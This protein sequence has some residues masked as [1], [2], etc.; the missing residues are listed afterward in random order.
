MMLLSDRVFSQMPKAV[1]R[2][3]EFIVADAGFDRLCSNEIFGPDGDM[4]LPAQAGGP[5]LFAE[6]V[7]KLKVETDP[8]MRQAFRAVMAENGTHEQLRTAFE[9]R[10]QAGTLRGDPLQEALDLGIVHE[11]DV[12]E[13]SH[14]TRDD[15]VQR[16]NWLIVRNDYREV[17]SKPELL[18]TAKR[19][20]FA[21]QLIG[22]QPHRMQRPSE[23]WSLPALPPLARPG[24]FP[25]LIAEGNPRGRYH[26]RKVEQFRQDCVDPLYSFANFAKD[27][28]VERDWRTDRGP[29]SELVD[30]GLEEVDASEFM[31]EVAVTSTACNETT[32]VP[33]NAQADHFAATKGLVERLFVARLEGDNVNWWREAIADANELTAC[34]FLAVLGFWCG[35]TV[36]RELLV[37]LQTLVDGVSRADWTRLCSMVDALAWAVMGGERPVGP[38]KFSLQKIGIESPRLA[39][40]LLGRGDD[41]EEV[42]RWGR[43]RFGDYDGEDIEIIQG[44][45]RTELVGNGGA[46]F[47]REVDWDYLKRLS[48]HARRIGTMLAM[49]LYQSTPLEIP[50]SVAASVLDDCSNYCA[51]LVS[52]CE[53]ALATKVAQRAS[54]VGQIA[55]DGRWFADTEF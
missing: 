14:F 8:I 54:R 20:F 7:A 40:L 28:L 21:R 39:Y 23:N 12:N 27:L 19:A 3:I 22:Y 11:F 1:K 35:E 6:C 45:A 5:I 49:P 37:E 4:A 52:V 31:V 44:A 17:M 51:H 2:L 30:Y 18:V 13:L 41:P 42:R 10:F 9:T 50:R 29:W 36:V 16:V 25:R 33:G 48:S 46:G 15:V 43:A 55:D 47:A 53:Q 32:A 34:Q 38:T 26:I 24:F